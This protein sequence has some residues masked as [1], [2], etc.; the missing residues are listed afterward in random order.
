[1]RYSTL[2][3]LGFTGALIVG[4]DS[5]TD[6]VPTALESGSGLVASAVAATVSARGVGVAPG[7][8]CD[9]IAGRCNNGGNGV[10]FHFD[11]SGANTGTDPVTVSGT[12]TASDR[13]TGVSL[14]FTGSTPNLFVVGHALGIGGTCNITTADGTTLPGP[15]FFC[16][17]DGTANGRGDELFFSGQAAN[18][19]IQ[20]SSSLSTS[21]CGGSVSLAS[22]NINI[23]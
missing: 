3:S 11:F 22:G 20:A 9:F 8:S 4:C 15:C 16:A 7:G 21:P 17:H 6:Q 5:R 18:G 12:W 14:Q 23:D 13:S 10:T 1:M 19:S 2:V